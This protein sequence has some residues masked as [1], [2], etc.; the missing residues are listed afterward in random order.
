MFIS[1]R[2]IESAFEVDRIRNA[3]FR[4]RKSGVLP[5]THRN[6]SAG[7]KGFPDATVIE[8]AG[9]CDWRDR[10]VRELKHFITLYFGHQL[11]HKH[12]AKIQG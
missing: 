11:R 5:R 10:K 6:M 4:T 2:I 3:S 7:F 8:F 9:R 12:Q 1:F